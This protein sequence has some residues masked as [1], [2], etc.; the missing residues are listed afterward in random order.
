MMRQSLISR[1][2]QIAQSYPGQ[3]FSTLVGQVDLQRLCR[4]VLDK[5]SKTTLKLLQLSNIDV[6]AFEIPTP[7]V[8]PICIRKGLHYI[9]FQQVD[10]VI[11][12]E[13]N[14]YL[15]D[16][17]HACDYPLSFEA[18]LFRGICPNRKCFQRLLVENVTDDVL[19]MSASEVVQRIALGKLSLALDNESLADL[20]TAKMRKAFKIGH[21][22]ASEK[23]GLNKLTKRVYEY[24]GGNNLHLQFCEKLMN[25]L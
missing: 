13:H 4:N 7:K 2:A 10:H 6:E 14:V 19:G 12:P 18:N 15:Q 3:S 25:S 24:I 22:I 8:C 20:H 21:Q 5:I 16:H 17:C 23:A 9:E 11:C 1:L